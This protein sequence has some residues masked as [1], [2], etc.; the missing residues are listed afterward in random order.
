MGF[1]YRTY[2]AL[3]SGIF[4]SFLA[5]FW[6]YAQISGRH[7]NGL[8]ERIG[9]IPPRVLKLSSG[10]P[11]I[12]LHASSLG[13]VK[14]AG[15]LR[16]H[17]Q[18]ML[19]RCSLILSTSTE[20]GRNLAMRFFQESPIIYAPIDTPFSVRRT[21]SKLKPDVLVFLETEI[22]PV[23][24]T[25][26]RRMGV[27]IALVNGRI[28]GR[29]LKRYLALQPFFRD[30]LKNVDVFSMILDEDGE[31]IRRMGAPSPRVRVNGNAKYE[32]LVS[33]ANPDVEAEA[34]EILNVAP[35]Q[36]VLVAGSTRSGE[37]E[38]I[39]DAYEKIRREFPQTLL[40]IAPRHIV[41]TPAIESMLRARSIRYHLRTDLG[42]P[43]ARVEPVV[44]VNTFGEL[45]KFYSVGMINFCG[46][47]LVH[48]G[49]QNPLEPAAWGKAVFYGPSMEDFLDAKALLESIGAGIEVANPEDLAVRAITLLNNPEMLKSKGEAARRALLAKRGAAERHARVIAELAPTS[50]R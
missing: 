43:G 22:W 39:L 29:S 19:P 40:V 36:V 12:W 41:R 37:E 50:P 15:A 26:A 20:H 9:L 21:L 18:Q 45:L 48:L 1:L 35:N 2:S 47:S 6:A 5:P 7:R 34:R 17:L 32:I 46:G 49:G 33:E 42:A 16:T 28:S 11:R 3:S 44:L 10:S 4:F 38:L 23:W 24:I 30:V 13:E 31:R 27:K 8:R 14:V 25:E